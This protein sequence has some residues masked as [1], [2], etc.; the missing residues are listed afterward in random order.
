MDKNSLRLAYKKQREALTP[1][2]VANK[3]LQIANQLLS[4][5][6]WEKTYFHLFLSNHSLKEVDTEYVLTLLQGKDKEVVVPRMESNDDLSHIL[7]TD[8]TAIKPNSFGIP[9][10]IGGI[11]VSPTTIEVVFVPLLAYD[12][13]GN[14]IGYGKGYYDR[15]LVQCDPEC[16]FIGLSFFP[17]EERIPVEKTDIKLQYCI[18]PEKIYSFL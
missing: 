9:E 12:L 3:S 4:L 2:Q 10:P 14:R 5:A 6:L 17:P 7:L 16:R 1:D 11:A 15:F 13:Q 18:T 8:A